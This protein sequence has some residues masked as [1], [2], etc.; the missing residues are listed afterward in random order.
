MTVCG[1][2]ITCCIFF[3]FSQ[4][5]A[6]KI[7]DLWPKMILKRLSSIWIFLLLK[8]W[9]TT[10]ISHSQSYV[11]VYVC[12]AGVGHT[13]AA[14]ASQHLSGVCADLQSVWQWD[15]G[16]CTPYRGQAECTSTPHACIH[17]RTH[18][19]LWSLLVH[20]HIDKS[21]LCE[22]LSVRKRVYSLLCKW[23]LEI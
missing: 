1:F 23:G 20:K 18:T 7:S 15:G 19:Y 6:L 12:V 4:R 13:G 17:T 2:S 8:A 14:G 3:C 21:S 16:I 10:S 22:I 5:T 9:V 11:F